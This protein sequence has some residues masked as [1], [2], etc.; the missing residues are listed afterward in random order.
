[1][2]LHMRNPRIPLHV[3]HPDAIN[4][5]VAP[6]YHGKSHVII[7]LVQDYRHG[8]KTA[9]SLLMPI[10]FSVYKTKNPVR[11]EKRSLS[12]LSLLGEV[13]SYNDNR[14]ISTRFDLSPGSYFIVPY[15]LSDNHSGQFLVRVLAEKDPVAGKTGCVV[16]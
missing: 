11:D 16:S 15:C 4:R 5:V 3:L 2:K 12:K 13:T 9:N 7:S 6:G 14:E 1:M 8:A 10:G